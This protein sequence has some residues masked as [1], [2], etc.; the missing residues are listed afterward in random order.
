MGRRRLKDLGE[1]EDELF[2]NSGIGFLWCPQ[3]EG[4]H[5]GGNFASMW[6]MG[7]GFGISH[8]L[9]SSSENLPRLNV[10]GQYKAPEASLKESGF[11]EL[12]SGA[13]AGAVS[14]T[15]VAPLETIRTHMM[16]GNYGH[17]TN[18]VFQNIMKNEGWKG[19][20]SGN[21]VNVIRVAPSKAIELFVYETFKKRLTAKPDEQ[22]RLPGPAS[23][24]SGAVAGISS[25]LCTYPLEL[26]K[27]R[28]T[29]QR[30]VYKNVLDAL[31]KIVK[32]E[33]P[34]ELYRGLTPS[35]IGVIP[36][37][38]TNYYAYD[39]LRKAYRQILKQEEIGSMATLLIG[40]AAGAISGGVTFPLEVA[41]KHMQAGA[42]NGRQYHNM[43]H[44][45]IS[46]LE[47][48]GVLGLY[49]G[50]G[51]SCLKLV[52]A[53]GISFMCYEACK[54]ILVEHENAD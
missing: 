10:F 9:Q 30:G 50:L 13:I 39:T 28:L 4:Y 36:Y 34:A 37:A 32:E 8:T 27:T 48:E 16:V 5:P 31:V 25:T 35:L 24:I 19:L 15:S 49:R 17:S 2:L 46:I 6:Q 11:P 20:F 14:R 40:S 53:A 1:N 23:L 18:E 41:R 45:L 52:P 12:I 33:G 26:L 47:H 44:A 21:L 22:P 3:D 54:K 38:A 51:P 29:L 42:L 7:M 43:L